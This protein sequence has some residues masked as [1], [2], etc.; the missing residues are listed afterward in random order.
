M[1]LEVQKGSYLRKNHTGDNQDSNTLSEP[2][3]IDFKTSSN[4]Q[5]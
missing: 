4:A 5:Q 3:K 1:T 2:F